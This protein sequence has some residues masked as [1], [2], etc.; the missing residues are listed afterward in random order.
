M[1]AH[2]LIRLECGTLQ[3]CE[4]LLCAALWSDSLYLEPFYLEDELAN[5]GNWSWKFNMIGFN[6]RLAAS[7]MNS[8][9]RANVATDESS[10]V[11]LSRLHR[12]A[13]LIF[14]HFGINCDDEFIKSQINTHGYGARHN[15]TYYV[16]AVPNPTAHE[17]LEAQLHLRDFL[18]DKVSPDELAELM[19]Q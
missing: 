7:G 3:E 2:S 19:G 13:E 14:S 10:F 16:V 8:A 17:R 18:R 9:I 11:L 5:G 4:R 15:L 6:S 12:L 1:S